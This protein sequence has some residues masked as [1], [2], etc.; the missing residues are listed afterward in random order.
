MSK[1]VSEVWDTI[2]SIR[3]VTET[4][5]KSVPEKCKI[6]RAITKGSKKCQ[7]NVKNVCQKCGDQFE[8]IEI[9]TNRRENV[10]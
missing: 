8:A 5:Q 3:K 9:Q 6:I 7:K 2:V 4:C 1:N 10:P